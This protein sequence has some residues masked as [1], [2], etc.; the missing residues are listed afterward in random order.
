VGRF[1]AAV[2]LVRTGLG[3][4]AD[5]F[6]KLADHR[7]ELVDAAALFVHHPVQLL[8]RVFLVGQLDFDIDKTL[9]SLL[10]SACP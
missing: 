6:G 8:D 1:F 2:A 4:I 3:V 5:V 10:L 7:F 9:P